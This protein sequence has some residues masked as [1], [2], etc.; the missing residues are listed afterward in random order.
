MVNAFLFLDQLY[1]CSQPLGCHS[2]LQRLDLHR[3]VLHFAAQFLTYAEDLFR[4][5]YSLMPSSTMCSVSSTLTRDFWSPCKSRISMPVC[6]FTFAWRF[7][8]PSFHSSLCSSCRSPSLE[9]N[10][11]FFCCCLF[12]CLRC[13]PSTICQLPF[14]STDM[15]LSDVPSS[16]CLGG[17]RSACP[18]HNWDPLRYSRPLMPTKTSIVSCLA[19]AVWPVSDG[20]HTSTLS[21]FDRVWGPV[22]LIFCQTPASTPPSSAPLLLSTHAWATARLLRP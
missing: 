16:S 6:T 3:C 9:L 11:C 4:E 19:P 8:C 21:F 14:E 5:K 17:D 7:F 12:F 10:S 13:R 18:S 22:S 20:Y 15:S 1:T 2:H